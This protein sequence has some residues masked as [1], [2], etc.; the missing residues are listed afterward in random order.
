MPLM[1][2]FNSLGLVVTGYGNGYPAQGFIKT[3]L[4]QAS[5]GGGAKTKSESLTIIDFISTT[6][7]QPS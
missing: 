3:R 1:M 5:C 2:A 6:E 4:A 7:S